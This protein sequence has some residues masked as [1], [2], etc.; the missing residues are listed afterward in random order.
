MDL[1][2]EELPIDVISGDIDGNQVACEKSDENTSV[3]EKQTSISNAEVVSNSLLTL[4]EGNHKVTAQ[5]SENE[6]QALHGQCDMIIESGFDN[7]EATEIS[8]ESQESDK[9]NPEENLE[10]RNDVQITSTTVE[11]SVNQTDDNPESNCKKRRGRRSQKELSD[12]KP[13]RVGVFYIQH[14]IT[15]ELNL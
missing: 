3:L 5:R 2:T 12:L 11:D 6:N 15:F 9:I 8:T 1:Y 14:K 10:S 13:T 7:E 4:P